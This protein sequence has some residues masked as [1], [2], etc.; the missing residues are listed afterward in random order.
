MNTAIVRMSWRS[1]RA[2]LTRLVL[3]LVA[4]VLG[5]SFVAGGFI[6]SASLSAGFDDIIASG[7]EDVDVV[8]RPVDRA[9]A[10]SF[11]RSIVAAE[12]DDVKGIARAEEV[13]NQPI[14]LLVGETPVQTGGAGAW[15]MPFE[16]DDAGVRG[17]AMTYI[18]GSSPSSH[19]EGTLNSSTAE[20]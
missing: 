14:T 1:L 17:G 18:E 13:D 3:S 4:V 15:I 20:K 12:L 7:Y 2:N 8:V 10:Q 9:A 11:D 5:T 6:L 19:Y 16:S